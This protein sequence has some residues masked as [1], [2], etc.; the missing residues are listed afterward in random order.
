M[1]DVR[2]DEVTRLVDEDAPAATG[3]MSYDRRTGL[4]WVTGGGP[5]MDA[6]SGVPRE[7]RSRAGTG[8]RRR[9][10]VRGTTLSW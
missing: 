8:R 3:G 9:L 2:D 5:R 1:G 6:E 10:V 7:S 4:L